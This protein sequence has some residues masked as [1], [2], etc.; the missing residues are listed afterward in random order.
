[1][2]LLRYL[3]EEKKL[4]DDLLFN[5]LSTYELDNAIKYMYEN[6]IVDEV[7]LNKAICEY[8]HLEYINLDAVSID[9]DFF[10]QFDKTLIKKYFVVPIR[11][12]GNVIEV[13]I[14]RPWD[15][16]FD[17]ECSLLYSGCVIKKYFC[18][19][20][21]IQRKIDE[22]MYNKKIEIN[23]QLSSNERNNAV[24][25]VDK[26]IKEAIIKRA[27]D[28]HFEPYNN[29][30]IRIRYRIDGDLVIIENNISQE[31][32]QNIISR[33]KV[34]AGLDPA[35]KRRPQDGRISNF[36]FDNIS[37]DMRVSTMSTIFGEKAVIRILENKADNREFS[38]LGFLPHE[39]NLIYNMMSYPNGIILV[40]GE[41]GSGKTTTLYTMLNNL[42]KENVNICTIEDPVESVL[43]GVNQVQVNELAGITFAE[44]LKTFLRQDPN[45][46]MVGE[47]R[48]YET[49]DIAFKAA[50]T[51]HLVLTT[52]HTNNTI[53]TINRLISMG[54]EPYRIIE[55]IRGIISQKLVK[56]LCPYCRIQEGDKYYAKGCINCVNGYVG[57]TVIPEILLF[58]ENI[59][60]ILSNKNTEKHIKEQLQQTKNYIPFE[61]SI[62]LRLSS[63]ITD[64][65]EIKK[66]FGF[67]YYHQKE[68]EISE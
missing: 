57:R 7:L 14:S 60:E 16:E 10:M 9:K 15:Y 25:L 53:S 31:E 65:K 58:D 61:Q 41:T 36:V 66:V 4:I 21:I 22:L 32:Y 46:I 56:K 35:E 52:L 37:Y 33:I 54:I 28:I 40:T 3:Y 50:N 48:D 26:I 68:D 2:S 18:S 24:E 8:Y 23:E 49:A 39:I 44:M 1:M 5:V 43:E 63:G 64:E 47:I 27:S 59:I 11:R 29:K 38:K 12:T 67:L 13:C 42:N 17:E 6:Q 45:I 20:L 19:P 30:Y 62:K 55:N 51:G 34:M